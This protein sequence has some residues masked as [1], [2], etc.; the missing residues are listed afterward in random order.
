MLRA[1]PL[2]IIQVKTRK[3]VLRQK[4]ED[5]NMMMS[6]SRDSTQRQGD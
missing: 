4:H 6:L 5:E 1:G 2:H 3:R